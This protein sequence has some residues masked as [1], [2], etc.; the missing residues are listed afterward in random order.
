MRSGERRPLM[1]ALR[2]P[3]TNRTNLR[4]E[5]ISVSRLGG[6]TSDLSLVVRRLAHRGSIGF[7]NAPTLEAALAN[8]T[9][10]ALA[11]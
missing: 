8:Q 4:K 6:H 7:N 1:Q 9:L 11:G 3:R 5:R 2:G 10:K